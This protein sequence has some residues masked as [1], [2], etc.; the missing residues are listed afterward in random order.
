M[1]RRI[2]CR[3]ISW[4]PL[5]WQAD[6]DGLPVLDGDEFVYVDE[7]T[8]ELRVLGRAV[9][10]AFGFVPDGEGG[11]RGWSVGS[12]DEK[13]VDA[14][15]GW[16]EELKAGLARF[17]RQ[18]RPG[19]V[20]QSEDAIEDVLAGLPAMLTVDD[21]AEA[22]GVSARTINRAIDTKCIEPVV[23]LAMRGTD[24]RSSLRIPRLALRALLKRRRR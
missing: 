17:A 4:K 13:D 15:P 21:A 16:A 10:G 7:E 12:D 1:V 11:W 6:D 2:E 20:P 23:D 5:S 24:E 18:R 9:G 19:G 14:A 22:L 3:V 8:G